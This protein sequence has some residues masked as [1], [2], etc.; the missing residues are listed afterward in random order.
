MGA[1]RGPGGPASLTR[2]YQRRMSKLHCLWVLAV[3]CGKSAPPQAPADP[4]LLRADLQ[5][6]CSEEAATHATGLPDL[7]PFLEPKLHDTEVAE[8]LHGVRDGTVSLEAFH[9][10]FVAL[11]EEQKVAPCPTLDVLFAPKTP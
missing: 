2:C 3:A 9:D 7:G 10:R 1:R 5:T 6:F 4:S 8:L 11:T